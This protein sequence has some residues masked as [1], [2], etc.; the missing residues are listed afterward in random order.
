MTE[1][2]AADGPPESQVEISPE[3][4]FQMVPD[5]DSQGVEPYEVFVQWERGEPHEHAET[6]DAP[7]DAMAAMLAKRNIDV[8]SE[9]L[10]IWVT[11]RRTLTRTPGTDPSLVPE[12]D[13]SYRSVQ[14]YAE[15]QVELEHEQSGSDH[16]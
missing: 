10:S 12:T 7:S 6:I 16:P 13:R 5:P 3:Q 14:W 2:D 1:D 11:P 9:P 4:A 8:R 15:H